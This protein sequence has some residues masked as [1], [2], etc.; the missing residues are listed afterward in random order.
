MSAD[1]GQRVKKRGEPVACPFCSKE[2]PRPAPLAGPPGAL[3]DHT[4]GRCECGGIYL[5]DATGR[6]G[7]QV[8]LD[9]LALLCEGDVQA[10]MR[11]ESGVDYELRSRLYNA[12]G[13][14]L[15]PTPARRS[16]YGACKLWFFRRLRALPE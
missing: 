14:A 2:L 10:A 7:G 12:R 5:L 13:H 1:D 3:S 9:G 6:E 8:L 15:E 11:L 16:S 4:G